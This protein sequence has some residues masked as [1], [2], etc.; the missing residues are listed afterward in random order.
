MSVQMEFSA[1]RFL[2]LRNGSYPMRILKKELE[3]AM[4]KTASALQAES[5]PAASQT[6]TFQLY[7]VPV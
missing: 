1:S 2:L 5:F 3:G 6:C 7:F 4:P